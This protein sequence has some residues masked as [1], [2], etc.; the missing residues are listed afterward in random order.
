MQKEGSEL[1][2][3]LKLEYAPFIMLVFMLN[4]CKMLRGGKTASATITLKTQ[5]FNC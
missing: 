3:V 2:N 5:R 1:T 4:N